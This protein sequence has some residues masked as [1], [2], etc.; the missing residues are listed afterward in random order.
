MIQEYCALF[1]QY[2]NKNSTSENQIPESKFSADPHPLKGTGPESCPRAGA[3]QSCKHGNS[4][5]LFTNQSNVKRNRASTATW[6]LKPT[7]PPENEQAN[8]EALG[9][10]NHCTHLLEEESKSSKSKGAISKNSTSYNP[11]PVYKEDTYL[12]NQDV[13]NVFKIENPYPEGSSFSQSWSMPRGSN[14]SQ[15]ESSASY[16]LTDT[17]IPK[18]KSKE[19]N[20]LEMDETPSFERNDAEADQEE[21]I[22][23]SDFDDCSL[24]VHDLAEADQSQGLLQF[25]FSCIKRLTFLRH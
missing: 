3:S 24:P 6:S 13:A 11:K 10:S 18:D 16:S 4:A 8:N 15:T 12:A 7:A 23:Q 19:R 5:S 2:E 20:I 1:L 22:R 14:N 21:H 25:A 9:N 17:L